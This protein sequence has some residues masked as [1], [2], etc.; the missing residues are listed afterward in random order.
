M[1]AFSDFEAEAGEMNRRLRF[2]WLCTWVSLMSLVFA[3]GGSR[4]VWLGVLGLCLG[5]L[6][7][8]RRAV[9]RLLAQVS[10]LPKSRRADA[11]QLL[12][13]KYLLVSLEDRP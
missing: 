7:I 6:L 4:W 1:L 9:I 10:R 3:S 5:G 11:R 13:S 2:L 12:R 8:A